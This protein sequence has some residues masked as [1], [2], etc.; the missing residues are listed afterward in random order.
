M[1]ALSTDVRNGL[2]ENA[3]EDLARDEY[4]RLWVATQDG[5]N[6]FDANKI[7]VFNSGQAHSGLSNSFINDIYSDAAGGMWV[8]SNGGIDRIDTHNYQIVQHAQHFAG[9]GAFDQLFRW[10]EQ[11]VGFLLGTE[12]YTINIHS[13]A[14]TKVPVTTPDIKSLVLV[15]GSLILQH[16]TGFS[17][18][19]PQTLTLTARQI[20]PVLS[21]EVINFTLDERGDLWLV[22]TEGVVHRCDAADRC[23]KLQFSDGEGNDAT[24]GSLLFQQGTMYLVSNLGLF[25]LDAQL[26]HVSLLQTGHQ[27]RVFSERPFHHVLL[28]TAE[29]DIFVGTMGG[30]YFLS[31]NFSHLSGAVDTD[32]I[33]DQEL[34]GVSTFNTEEGEALAVTGTR[35]L[36]LLKEDLGRLEVLKRLAYPKDFE[37]FTFIE[38]GEHRYLSSFRSGSLLLTAQGW[39]PLEQMVPELLGNTNILTDV[40]EL[41]T[42][43][44]LLLFTSE[45]ILITP[46]DGKYNIRWR[47]GLNTDIA[48]DIEYQH[49]QLLIATLE[50]G[51]MVA[52]WT[53]KMQPPENWQSL[54]QDVMLADLKQTAN[55]LI[56]MTVGDGI[57]RLNNTP[58]GWQAT[59]LES[60]SRLL[61]ATI[62][63]MTPYA[64]NNGWLVT[65]NNGVVIYDEQLNLQQIL[66]INDGLSHRENVQFACTSFNNKAVAVGL[67]GMTIFH[68]AIAIKE[69]AKLSWLGAWVDGEP[70]PMNYTRHNFIAPDQLNFRF[71]VGPLPLNAHTDFQ[72]RFANS[73]TSWRPLDDTLLSLSYLASGDYHLEIRGKL[74]NGS[75]T[76]TLSVPF[77]ISPP[78]WKQNFALVLYVVIGL[79]IINW[80]FHLRWQAQK[81]RVVLLE[82]QKLLQDNY[83]KELESQVKQRTEELKLKQKEALKLQR[84]KASFIIGASHDLKNLVGLLRLNLASLKDKQE[85]EYQALDNVTETLSDLTENITQLSKMDAGAISPVMV[86]VELAPLL[87]SIQRQ[88]SPACQAKEIQFELTCEPQ[89][90]VKTDPHLLARILH[91]LIDNAIKNLPSGSEIVLAASAQNSDCIIKVR[92][93][94]TGLPAEI[95]QTWPVPFWRGTD[96]YSGSGLGLFVVS[97]IAQLLSISVKLDEHHQGACFILKLPREQ[98]LCESNALHKAHIIALIE[99][100]PQQR[101]WLEQKLNNHGY[102]VDSFASIKAFELAKSQD[103][104]AILSDI[105]LEDDID[106]IEALP[107]YRKR[108]QDK[109]LVIYISGHLA[110]RSRIDGQSRV[111]FLPKP[112]KLLK[113]FNLLK[114]GIKN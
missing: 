95:K 22:T 40:L 19:D 60:N 46:S 17:L 32:E 64:E 72:Y 94:G 44:R 99:D 24:V 7:K 80:I 23:Q 61:N 85:F 79:L 49:Q 96:Q 26:S 16:D 74:Y 59:P 27:W 81:E 3:V 88:F 52:P 73:E 25:I 58:E 18:L 38:A 114:Q 1:T 92:D 9:K 54:M 56:A 10:D 101:L 91:N 82:A 106:G 112:L 45:L 11:H 100:D 31:S 5:V 103:Y 76:N 30:L 41:A 33:F 47:V 62:L 65:T 113:L 4:Q 36:I 75:F 8:A 48:Y 83:T 108:M 110:A 53:D 21:D 71:A 34:V 66:T 28:V 86:V 111:Y 55:E 29:Q 97:K 63:C 13:F 6:L 78:I 87:N 105:D 2:S 109:G 43:E 107:L 68:K 57:W 15:D 50:D 14:I 67:R 84:D 70:I 93:N 35:E 104:A 12:L 39:L 90:F 69:Q 89:L 102:Q 42:G 20:S 77:K 98:K 51:L 37:P